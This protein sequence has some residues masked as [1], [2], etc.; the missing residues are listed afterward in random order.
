LSKIVC[1]DHKASCEFVCT[2]INYADVWKKIEPLMIQIQE[3]INSDIDCEQCQS[4]GTINFSGFRDYI[5]LGIGG[6]AFDPNNFIKFYSRVVCV[7]NTAK[8]DKRI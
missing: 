5:K 6:E 4:D 7:Y 1:S 8:E 3:I 2:G